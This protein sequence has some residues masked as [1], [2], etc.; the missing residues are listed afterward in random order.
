[1]GKD[2]LGWNIWHL[3][4]LSCT[5]QRSVIMWINWCTQRE[6]KKS[7]IIASAV[8][9]SGATAWADIKPRICRVPSYFPPICSFLYSFIVSRKH[10]HLLGGERRC[11]ACDAWQRVRTVQLLFV[12]LSITAVLVVHKLLSCLPYRATPS[13]AQTSRGVPLVSL[14]YTS[15]QSTEHITTWRELEIIAGQT[16]T[17]CLCFVL[18]YLSPESTLLWR[19]RQ[20]RGRQRWDSLF[21]PWANMRSLFWY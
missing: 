12:V 2:T 19:Q 10:L 5:L 13:A 11:V 7:F 3:F 4:M 8:C 20:E 15:K 17:A 1:M 6:L 16:S 14:L 18:W 21:L 9:Y